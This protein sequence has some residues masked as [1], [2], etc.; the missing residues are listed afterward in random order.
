MFGEVIMEGEIVT[1][2]LTR[3]DV[4]HRVISYAQNGEDVLLSR[5][6]GADHAGVYV[7]VGANDPIFHSV[8]KLLYTRGWR[9][10]NIEPTPI[11]HERLV[12]DRPEDVNLNV[13]ISDAEGTLTFF[14]VPPP[15]HGWS[16]FEPA[17]A[18]AYR[19]GEGV[20]SVPRPIP[21]TTLNHVFEQYVGRTNGRRPQDRR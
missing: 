2:W 6:F 7:D 18:E 21:V 14:E 12:V 19:R 3:E 4:S 8:T 5:V 9:G 20:E 13:G 16:T 15:L 10:V 17:V 11:L 1:R